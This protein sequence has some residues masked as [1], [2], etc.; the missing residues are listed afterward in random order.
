MSQHDKC[1]SNILFPN[2]DL[3]AFCLVCACSLLISATKPHQ[4]AYRSVEA[5]D[6]DPAAKLGLKLSADSWGD[7]FEAFPILCLSF[8]CHFNILSVRAKTKKKT[9]RQPAER[10]LV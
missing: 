5:N 9:E 10:N 3:A 6:L 4:I 8:L 1:S 7:I 2:A